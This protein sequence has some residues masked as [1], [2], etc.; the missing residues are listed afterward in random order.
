M[1]LIS[2]AYTKLWTPSQQS[3]KE[4]INNKT[5]G[6]VLPN[7]H[8]NFVSHEK[9]LEVGRKRI[10]QALHSQE[11]YERGIIV[12]GSQIT[13]DVKGE[14][15]RVSF[16]QDEMEDSVCMHGHV[17]STPI[18]TDDYFIMLL[19]KAKE[20][21][22]INPNGEYSKLTRLSPPQ[23]LGKIPEKLSKFLS[24]LQTNM[25]IKQ[26]DK[27]YK[28]QTKDI[29]RQIS[30]ETNKIVNEIRKIIS[31]SD[32]ETTRHISKCIKDFQT[33]GIINTENVPDEMKQVMLRWK[34][35]DDFEVKTKTPITDEFWTK[36][37]PQSIGA[38]YS[39][40]YS[41]ICRS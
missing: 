10:L 41:N 4:A 22:A 24:E 31:Q 34:K 40:D 38:V 1:T 30:I 29:D 20:I 39:T 13:A 9:A 5:I 21:V 36:Q 6:Y 33:K 11:P 18:S 3:L 16:P 25:R 28:A 17:Q 37:D 2:S 26:V 19:G 12:K 35:L 27:Q 32:P 8:V 15:N 14:H 23:W 7:N